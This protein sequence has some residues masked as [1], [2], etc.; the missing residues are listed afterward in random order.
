[1]KKLIF[2]VAACFLFLLCSGAFAQTNVSKGNV[3]SNEKKAEDIEDPV[4]SE[5]ENYSKIKNDEDKKNDINAGKGKGNKTSNKNS[6]P[7]KN[8]GKTDKK[9]KEVKSDEDLFEQQKDT[10]N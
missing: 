5:T 8:T 9:T 7:P 2:I 4:I 6:T 3:N 1:M 10:I